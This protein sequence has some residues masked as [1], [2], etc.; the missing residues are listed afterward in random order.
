MIGSASIYD[1]LFANWAGIV[2]AN[3]INNLPDGESIVDSNKTYLA[4]AYNSYDTYLVDN[5]VKRYIANPSSFDYYNFNWSKIC[6]IY[7]GPELDTFN[8]MTKGNTIIIDN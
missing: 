5:G 8:N 4:K 3:G 1:S 6:V 7:P 2:E